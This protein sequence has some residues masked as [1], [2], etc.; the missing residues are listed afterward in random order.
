MRAFFKSMDGTLLMRDMVEPQVIASNDVKIKVLCNTLG[1]EDLRIF[2]ESDLYSHPG[3]AGYEMTG[4]IVDLGEQAVREGF[5]VGQRVTGTPLLF[6]GQCASCLR[7][8]ENCCSSATARGGTL[9]EYI[10]W[11]SSQLVRLSDS[12]SDTLGCLVE[13]VATVLEALDRLTLSMNDSVCILGGDFLG[14]VLV[15]ILRLQGVREIVLVDTSSRKR[16]LALSLGADYAVNPNQGDFT[17]EFMRI[18]DYLGFDAIVETSGEHQLLQK[19]MNLL[20]KGGSM[21]FMTYY[22][23]GVRISADSMNF[24]ISNCNIYSSCLYTKQKL[25]LAERLLPRLR[26]DALMGPHFPFEKTPQA[27][28]A[29]QHALYPRVSIGM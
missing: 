27:F 17:T 16:E 1:T 23:A 11:T 2:R 12:I 15:Q 29:V 4:V 24:Y 28:D 3:I 25:L 10:V 18:T 26:L 7:G 22:E 9:C 8:R 20:A 14:L 6:C 21:L 5:A 19:A 13:P